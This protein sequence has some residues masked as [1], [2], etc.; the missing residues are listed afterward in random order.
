MAS[1]PKR[2]SVFAGDVQLERLAK[3]A[4]SST[5]STY[6]ES[7]LESVFVADLVQACAMANRP[8]VELARA[9][10]D[11]QGYDLVATCGQVTR[12]IQL[13]SSSAP[14]DLQRSLVD[15]PS[16]CCVLTI[17]YV[18][19]GQRRIALDYLC[20]ARLPTNGSPSRLG[21]KPR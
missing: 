5:E 4:R 12:H 6:R 17:P 15:K 21:R 20:T 16:A 11:F 8:W 13:K 18:D 1:A 19:A 14:V 10:V 3:L 2:N 7:L 9:F